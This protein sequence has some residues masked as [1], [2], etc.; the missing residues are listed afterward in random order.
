MSGVLR[1]YRSRYRGLVKTLDMTQ[2]VPCTVLVPART[3]LVDA[4][5]FLRLR[6]ALGTVAGAQKAAQRGKAGRSGVAGVSGGYIRVQ[7]TVNGD[8]VML[9]A[10]F[11][12]V[13]ARLQVREGLQNPVSVHMCQTEGAN[14]RGVDDP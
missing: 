12:V 8:A 2:P 14:A 13:S 11:A 4:A 3:Q 10:A 6:T 9:A 7:A 1:A 5:Q